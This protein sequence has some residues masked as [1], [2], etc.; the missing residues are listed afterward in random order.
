[1]VNPNFYILRNQSSKLTEVKT[2]YDKEILKKCLITKPALQKRETQRWEG[3]QDQ[4]AQRNPHN[5]VGEQWIK[6]GNKWIIA[7][8]QSN[9]RIL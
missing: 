7:E 2:F 3:H 4:K 6:G 5:Y 8:N 9:D 1:M